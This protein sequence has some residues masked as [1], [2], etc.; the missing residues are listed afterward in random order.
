[1]KES[2]FKGTLK[3]TLCSL[4]DNFEWKEG[5]T[6]KFGLVRVEFEDPP[7]RKP[8]ESHTWYAEFIKSKIRESLLQE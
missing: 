3:A 4:L 1:M 5:F 6:K 8:K 2:I 7:I